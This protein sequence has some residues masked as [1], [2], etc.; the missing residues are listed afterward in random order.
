MQLSANFDDW[1]NM[2]PKDKPQA[3][4]EIQSK[5]DTSEPLVVSGKTVVVVSLA[6]AA[7]AGA[8]AFLRKHR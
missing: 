2:T 5:N 3:T 6:A 1:T 7:A 4:P 8:F